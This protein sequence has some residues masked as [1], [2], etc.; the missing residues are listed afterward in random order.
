VFQQ[1]KKGTKEFQ[2]KLVKEKEYKKEV[3]SRKMFESL[4][5]HPKC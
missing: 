2:E 4:V 1:P 5:R 3:K